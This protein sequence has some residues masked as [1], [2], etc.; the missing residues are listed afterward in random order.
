[1]NKIQVILAVIGAGEGALPIVKKAKEMNVPAYYIF[2]DEELNKI[3]T[4]KPVT[5]EKLK[6][7]L[8][9]IKVKIHGNDII[10]ILNESK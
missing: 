9:S 4:L 7:I 6:E 3:I 2:N 10:K 1:M 5:I 8:P